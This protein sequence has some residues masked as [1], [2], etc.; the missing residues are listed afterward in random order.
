MNGFTLFQSFEEGVAVLSRETVVVAFLSGD[1]GLPLGVYF[2]PPSFS[3]LDW[4]FSLPPCN[5]RLKSATQ[6]DA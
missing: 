6:D 1:L 2:L 4:F 3:F 5:W